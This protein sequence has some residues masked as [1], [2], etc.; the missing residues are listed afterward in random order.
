MKN[1]IKKLK[2][3]QQFFLQLDYFSNIWKNLDLTTKEKC[4]DIIE[5]GI[6]RIDGKGIIRYEKII[7]TTSLYSAP[8]NG[9]VAFLK[10]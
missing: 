1:E 5:K 2:L 3:T 10:S 4:L 8:E 7:A 9:V 6:V